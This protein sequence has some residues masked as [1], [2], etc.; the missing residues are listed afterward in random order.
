MKHEIISNSS[1]I[2]LNQEKS[3]KFKIAKDLNKDF[4][5]YY[6]LIYEY[7]TAVAQ[8]SI[9]KVFIETETC[10]LKKVYILL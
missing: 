4:T 10:S 6:D 8:L 1:K 7:E 3:L 5:E 2:K 9:I